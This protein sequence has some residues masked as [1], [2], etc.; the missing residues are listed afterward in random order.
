MPLPAE[1]VLPPQ[2]SITRRGHDVVPLRG[3]R[4]IYPNTRL[5]C[6][7]RVYLKLRHG[8]A[9]SA[10]PNLTNCAR[11]APP[12]RGYFSLQNWS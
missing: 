2:A 4:T 9:R 7:S 12:G 8:S 11:S 6:A 5:N 10:P 1:N 3:T